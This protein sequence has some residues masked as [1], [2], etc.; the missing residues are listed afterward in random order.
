MCI[1]KDLFNQ[2]LI[3]KYFNGWI[4]LSV[5]LPENPESD[6]PTVYLEFKSKCTASGSIVFLHKWQRFEGGEQLQFSLVEEGDGQLSCY[7]YTPGFPYSKLG[8]FKRNINLTKI[9]Q[10]IELQ[11]QHKRF[12]LKARYADKNFDVQEVDIKDITVYLDHLNYQM[13]AQVR[14]PQVEFE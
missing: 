2:E 6:L 13:R 7:F 8:R 5:A 1:R 10:F 9:K 11:K 14:A 12:Q 4:G 3:D